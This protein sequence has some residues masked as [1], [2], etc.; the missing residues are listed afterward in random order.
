ML[1]FTDIDA[2]N[3][4]SFNHKRHRTSAI[5]ES[6]ASIANYPTKLRIYLTN[7]SPFWQVRCFIKGRAYTKSLRTTSR[8]VAVRGAKDFFHRT[9]A[10]IYGSTIVE[11]EDKELLFKDLVQPTIAIEQSRASRGELSKLGLTIL[12]NRLH[13][14]VLP[15]F[16]EM[17][18]SKIGYNEIAD[19]IHKLSNQNSSRTTHPKIHQVGLQLPHR[20]CG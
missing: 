20:C 11:R 19:F 3:D 17:P 10:E 9:V 1:V 4:D 14:T 2:V 8:R 18:I 5:S 15:H 13:K 6:V 16:S 12:Q 7:A